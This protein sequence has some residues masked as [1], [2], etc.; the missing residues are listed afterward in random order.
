MVLC[1]PLR[2]RYKSASK[3][4]PRPPVSYTIGMGVTLVLWAASVACGGVG[5]SLAAPYK[6]EIDEASRNPEPCGGRHQRSCFEYTERALEYTR[7]IIFMSFAA[8]GL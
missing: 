6:R 8:T 5:M 1:L 7:S 4:T 2:L 3:D